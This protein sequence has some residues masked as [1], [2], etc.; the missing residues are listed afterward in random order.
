[1]FKPAI[2]LVVV[3]CASEPASREQ[4]V[5]DTLAEDNYVWG[6]REPSLV[7]MS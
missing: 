3:G 6:L 5:L 1:M 2:A 4:R 7:A